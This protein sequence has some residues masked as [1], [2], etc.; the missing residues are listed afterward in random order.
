[1]GDGPCHVQCDRSG[2]FAAVANYGGGNFSLFPVGS[3]GRPRTVVR[4]GGWL[5]AG[6]DKARQAGPHAHQTV[7]DPSNKFMLGVDLGIDQILVYRFD[8]ASGR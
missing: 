5:G 4:G 2:R 6:A 8:Q 7:F 3:D 1:M